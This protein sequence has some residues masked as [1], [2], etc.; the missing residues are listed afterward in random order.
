MTTT[1]SAT[2]KAAGE[3]WSGLRGTMSFGDYVELVLKEKAL[4]RGAHDYVYGAVEWMKE[5]VGGEGDA[6]AP[7]GDL[8]SLAVAVD[9]AV[10]YLKLAAWGDPMERRALVFS[11]PPASGSEAI[12]G[13]IVEAVE[14]YSRSDKGSIYAI[15]GCP[16]S[17]DPLN[18]I[19]TGYRNE[20]VA[21]GSLQW[22]EGRLC[23]DCRQ[24]FRDQLGNE[25]L[26]DIEVERIILGREEGAGVAVLSGALSHQDVRLAAECSNRGVLVCENLTDSSRE[27]VESVLE[28]ASQRSFPVRLGQSRWDGVA[29][30]SVDWKAFEQMSED[31]SF[32]RARLRA[33]VVPVPY[34]MSADL[35]VAAYEGHRAAHDD[36]GRVH[37]S[38]LTLPTIANLAL[39][40]RDVSA[41]TPAGMHGLGPGRVMS[42]L[43]SCAAEEGVACVTP[44]HAL[45]VA[46][47]YVE[48]L[49]DQV[50]AAAKGYVKVAIETLRKAATDGF[51]EQAESLLAGYRVQLLRQLNQPEGAVPAVGEG[52]PELRTMEEALGVKDQDR[53]ELRAELGAYFERNPGGAYTDEPRM[54]IAIESRLLHRLGKIL[55][56]LRE[57]EEGKEG[58]DDWARQRGAVHDRLMNAYGFCKVCAIDLVAMLLDT[59]NPVGV[60][61]GQVLWKWPER[62]GAE[63]AVE[64][65]QKFRAASSSPAADQ[66]PSTSE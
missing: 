20:M 32:T 40:T 49:P 46:T 26:V 15:S 5:V 25:K 21:S 11:G 28:L 3:Y 22:A 59:E 57:V 29:I 30:A 51:E 54:K 48:V 44:L 33:R 61:K 6:R 7:F 14:A 45:S 18:L 34:S 50:E 53:A 19:D 38:P 64:E 12:W 2:L 39:K 42:V 4:N 47:R 10:D 8:E 17:E 41:E 43:E 35:E 63:K 52:E 13:R 27:V 9:Q 23:P 31:P 24:R 66:S 62:Y 16:I 55:R 65:L 37:F 58:W 60:K 1:K 36:L 56:D